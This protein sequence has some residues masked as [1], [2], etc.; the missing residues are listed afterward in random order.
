MCTQQA[1][2]QAAAEGSDACRETARFQRQFWGLHPRLLSC[3]VLVPQEP[4][5]I[6]QVGQQI[7]AVCSLWFEQTVAAAF[8]ASADTEFLGS[9]TAYLAMNGK[10][11]NFFK[12]NFWSAVF[13]I[14]V[15]F[16]N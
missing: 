13:D 14:L 12:L 16:L 6:S 15:L 2:D 8:E 9:P 5:Q 3:I 1:A 10:G 11:G 4:A 7:F